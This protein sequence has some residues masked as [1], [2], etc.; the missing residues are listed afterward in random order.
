MEK[1]NCFQCRHFFVTW[2]QKSPRGCRAYGFKS[3]QLPSAVVLKTSGHPC[4]QFAQKPGK[5]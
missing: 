5:K 3:N 1:V 2:D 4:Y